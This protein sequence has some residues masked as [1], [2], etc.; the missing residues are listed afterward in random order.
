MYPIMKPAQFSILFVKFHTIIIPDF[1]S[2]VKDT[3]TPSNHCAVALSDFHYA[4]PL[5]KEKNR[6]LCDLGIFCR[7]L[8]F[9]VKFG[10]AK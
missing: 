7:N 5:K 3:A 1:L 8:G 4:A 9:L 10:C 6:T 2:F